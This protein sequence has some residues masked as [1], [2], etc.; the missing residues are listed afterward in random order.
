MSNPRGRLGPLRIKRIPLVGGPI[1]RQSPGAGNSWPSGNV[2]VATSLPN[3]D[4]PFLLTFKTP[5]EKY[6]RGDELLLCRA[7][8]TEMNNA[9][10]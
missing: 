1:N 7:T 9:L 5:R 6:K 4:F 2:Y 8:T 10:E 3:V